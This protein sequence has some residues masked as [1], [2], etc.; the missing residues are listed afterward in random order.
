[1][2]AKMDKHVLYVALMLEVCLV[3]VSSCLETGSA[4][5]SQLPKAG[6]IQGILPNIELVVIFVSSLG[7][8][9]V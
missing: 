2:A 7:E 1:M 8:S 3:L 4:T 5:Q 9:V 6:R